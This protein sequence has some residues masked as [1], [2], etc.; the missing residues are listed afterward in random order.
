MIRIL[1]LLFASFLFSCES[2]VGFN[3]EDRGKFKIIEEKPVIEIELEGKVSQRDA[4]LSG[5]TWYKD[6]LIL[7]PQFPYLF[8]D[9]ISGAIFY[10]PK[11]KIKQYLQTKNHAPIK[12]EK[13]KFNADGFER[14]NYDGSGYEAIAFSGDTVF[15]SIESYGGETKGYTA[16]GKINFD[17]REIRLNKKSLTENDFTNRLPNHTEETITLFKDRLISIHESNG[18]NV[19][20]DS[21]AISYSL[22]LDEYTKLDFPNIEYRITDATEIY[23]D[24]TFWAINYL[25]QGDI[26]LLNPA[27]D[28]L[29]ERFGIGKSH[30]DNAGVERLIKM[31]ILP[32]SISV[33]DTP[34]IY[35]ELLPNGKSRNW[36]GIAVLDNLGFIIASD[37]HPRTILA[38]V[39]FN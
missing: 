8:G 6:K 34:P 13:L 36:E 19:F 4:E 7:L 31:K 27:N 9:G 21:Y 23:S 17:K 29:F 12:P 15:V 16:L 39:P 25:W 37:Q 11:E 18:A 38:F 2:D 24:S 1:I 28:E 26:E 10:I 30:K 33:T 3:L 20:S 22:N 14:F 32:N 35:L 5:L